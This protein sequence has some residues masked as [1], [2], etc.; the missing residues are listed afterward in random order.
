MSRDIAENAEVKRGG[1]P[2]NVEGNEERRE[3]LPRVFI[4]RAYTREATCNSVEIAPACKSSIITTLKRN[5]FDEGRNI[6]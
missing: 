5:Y 1:T 2:R 4:A 3:K 6:M